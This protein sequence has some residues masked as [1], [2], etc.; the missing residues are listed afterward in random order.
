MYFYNNS[1]FNFFIFHL[2][3]QSST[4]K[5]LAVQYLEGNP[6]PID[7]LEDGISIGNVEGT[8]I[9]VGVQIDKFQAGG[10]RFQFDQGIGVMVNFSNLL[11]IIYF[12]VLKTVWWHLSRGID[13]VQ[14]FIY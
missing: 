6:T 11:H 10:Y 1:Y 3:S 13:Y 4:S 12:D 14:R 7:I 2:N 8:K 5:K 9:M